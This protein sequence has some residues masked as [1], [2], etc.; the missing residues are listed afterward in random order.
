MSDFIDYDLGHQAGGNVVEVE[1]DTRANVQLV[2]SSN[3]QKYRRGGQ[4]RYYGG[5]A[6]RSPIRLEV[7]YAGHWHVVIDLG[8]GSGDVRSSVQVYPRAA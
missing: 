6:L 3:F 7:P 8:G 2:D 4:Y 5:Q 1:L